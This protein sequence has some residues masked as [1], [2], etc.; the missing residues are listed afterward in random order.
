MPRPDTPTTDRDQNTE[1]SVASLLAHDGDEALAVGEGFTDP[2]HAT[3]ELDKGDPHTLE[4][5]KKLRQ[6]LADVNKELWLVLSMLVIAFALDSLVS[7]K[8]VVLG[9][10][11]LPTLYSAYCLGR[12]HATLTALASICLVVLLARANPSMLRIGSLSAFSAYELSDLI[13][14]TPGIRPGW[15]VIAKDDQKRIVTPEAAVRNGAD[16]IVVGR[17]IRDAKSPADAAKKVAEEIDSALQCEL[18]P[19]DGHKGD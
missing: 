12:R 7:S 5:G 19:V 2:R 9:F 15:S 1:L 17:P 3:W 16:Y 10:Y 11:T 13:A 18:V 4:R 8:R 6:R 14:V